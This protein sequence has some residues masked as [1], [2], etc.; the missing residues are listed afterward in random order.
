[1][2]KHHDSQ[3]NMFD[4]SGMLELTIHG[5]FDDEAGHHPE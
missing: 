2:N 4:G 1:M 3:A 5:W